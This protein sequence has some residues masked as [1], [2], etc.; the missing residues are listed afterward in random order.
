MNKKTLTITIKKKWF[1]MIASGEKKEEY[2]EIK[3][4]YLV[5]FMNLVGMPRP[6]QEEMCQDLQKDT[7]S[8]G[9]AFNNHYGNYTGYGYI[10][11]RNGY[12]KTSPT[13]KVV[14]EWVEVAKGKPQWGAEPEKKYFVIRLGDIIKTENYETKRN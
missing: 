4:Y 14:L 5:R 8:S 3:P 2:R 9:F 10:L 1:D 6:L 12:S 7:M 11:F 13:I